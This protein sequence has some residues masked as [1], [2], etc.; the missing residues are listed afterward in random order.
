[1]DAWELLFDRAIDCL[2]TIPHTGSPMPD[3]T[4]GGGTA[5]ML[6]YAHRNSH[7]ID[8]FLPD[9]QWL[10]LLSPRFN[11]T[12]DAWVSDYQE[13][14]TWLKLAMP[15]GEIDFIV[16][17]DL[18]TSPSISTTI[19]GRPVKIETPAE[20]IAKKLRHRGGS[21]RPRDILDIAVVQSRDPGP[22]WASRRAWVQELPAIRRRL[23]ALATQY[24]VQSNTL[25][26]L[27]AGEPYRQT[28]WAVVNAF[29]ARV[30]AAERYHDSDLER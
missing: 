15:M 26:L 27:P 14:P 25:D 5:L 16:A 12:I 3:W 8:I 28:A 6:R 9:P 19:H 13:G 18:T 22:L 2:D 21:L 11:D 20:I 7:D 24:P 17:L 23:D 4:F 30:H 1:M 10:S 29:I